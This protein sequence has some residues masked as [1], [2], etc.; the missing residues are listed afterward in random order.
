MLLITAADGIMPRRLGSPEP[1]LSVDPGRI[2][3]PPFRPRRHPRRGASH[4]KL[5]WPR[6][7]ATA[8]RR[9]LAARPGNMHN[10]E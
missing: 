10:P 2:L 3:I 4:V 9:S 5:L 8:Q 1:I 6:R 7:D